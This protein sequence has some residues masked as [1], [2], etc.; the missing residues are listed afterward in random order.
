MTP[1]NDIATQ[2]LGAR[3]L[4]ERYKENE[5]LTSAIKKT[6]KESSGNYY[7]LAKFRNPVEK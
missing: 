7:G 3:C 2:P 4:P 5:N 6:T 1:R